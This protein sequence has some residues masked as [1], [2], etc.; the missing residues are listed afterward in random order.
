MGLFGKLVQH[1]FFGRLRVEESK[2]VSERVLNF[3]LL[4]VVF[5][6]AI[7]DLLSWTELMVYI[8]WFSVLGFLK[9]F[10][11]LARDRFAFLHTIGNEQRSLYRWLLSLLFLILTVDVFW[12]SLC[13]IYGDTSIGMF[14][15]LTFECY[16]IF[17]DTVQTL[18]I[19]MLHTIRRE[20]NWGAR[21][22]YI[23]YTECITDCLNLLA[24]FAHYCHI[25]YMHGISFTLVDAVLFLNMKIVFNQ[26]K[27]KIHAFLAYHR[28]IR[29][30]NSKFPT[31]EKEQ[32][33]SMGFDNTCLICREVMERAKQLPCCHSFHEDCLRSW[34]EY[35][36]NCPTCRHSLVIR[37]SD[38]DA[39]N[40]RQN[41]NWLD[42]FA[43]EQR[44][45]SVTP[46]MIQ[47]VVDVA[48]HVPIDV[49]R[50]DLATTHSPEMTLDNIFQG[51]LEFE[52]VQET[53]PEENQNPPIVNTKP[54]SKIPAQIPS[55]FANTVEERERILE[56]RKKAALEA[57]KQLFLKKLQQ[58]Q[59]QNQSDEESNDTLSES[60]AEDA[61]IIPAKELNQSNTREKESIEAR[62]RKLIEA[63]ER[64]E[65][66]H[67]TNQL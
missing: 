10:T 63:V 35:H 56:A 39:Q 41:Q 30:M 16:V 44:N 59:E 36:Q 22:S 27:D 2:K 5:T 49:I 12:F 37:S 4:K 40:Q 50:T 64:R 38:N 65:R 7:L 60:S 52:P 14:F 6:S 18:L 46:Q 15:L 26:L 66:Q 13:L 21:S 34:L 19:Y 1:I 20:S 48:P 54:K 11:L 23:Y 57:S 42:Y 61:T 29:A 28:M 33:E 62:R 43:H 25:L 3:I 55:G 17:F 53:G 8:T 51:R 58:R 32:L 24:T 9:V 45:S 67:S 47:Q 31:I